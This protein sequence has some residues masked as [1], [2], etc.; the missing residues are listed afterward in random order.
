M[1]NQEEKLQ[2]IHF[3]ARKLISTD[4]ANGTGLSILSRIPYNSNLAQN[5]TSD[6]T[7]QALLIY[8]SSEHLQPCLLADARAPFQYSHHP[9]LH[10]PPKIA[11]YKIKK[12][13]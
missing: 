13:N 9:L 4:S 2:S 1:H 3:V 10:S 12:R 5:R 8:Y 7:R 11:E 6:L